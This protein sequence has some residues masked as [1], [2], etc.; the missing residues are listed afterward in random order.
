MIFTRGDRPSKMAPRSCVPQ[1][2]PS[3]ADDRRRKSRQYWPTPTPNELLSGVCRKGS[4]DRSRVPA[5]PAGLRD[6][7]LFPVLTDGYFRTKAV[8][9]R[10]GTD[11][12]LNAF[13]LTA[14]IAGLANNLSK[15]TFMDTGRGRCLSDRDRRTNRQR[16]CKEC[17]FRSSRHLFLLFLRKPRKLSTNRNKSGFTP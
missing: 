11:C 4:Y 9:C 17:Q 8:E 15:L 3:R 10:I 14:V 5:T 13:N 6:E 1:D 2:F 16:Q 12:D 7:E